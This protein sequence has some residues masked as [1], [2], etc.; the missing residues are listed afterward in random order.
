MKIK[1]FQAV[2]GDSLNY[3]DEVINEFMKG[4]RVIDIE[5]SQSGTTEITLMISVLYEDGDDHE[6]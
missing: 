1:T 5:T 4:K 2:N 6:A 3:V